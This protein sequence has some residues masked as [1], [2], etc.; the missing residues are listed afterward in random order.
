MED[1]RYATT[2]EK[3]WC[4]QEGLYKRVRKYTHVCIVDIFVDIIYIISLK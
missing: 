1:I 4:I 3:V 2:R